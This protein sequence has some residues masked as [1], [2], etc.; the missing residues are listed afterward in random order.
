MAV[1]PLSTTLA[2][3]K[4]VRQNARHLGPVPQVSGRPTESRRLTCHVQVSSSFFNT[5]LLAHDRVIATNQNY[6]QVK[7]IYKIIIDKMQ[8]NRQK[9]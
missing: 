9:Y 8:R 6:E 2:L 5:S 3:G 1:V 7:K 4:Q